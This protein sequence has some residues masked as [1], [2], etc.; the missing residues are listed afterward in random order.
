MA[1]VA[2]G[3]DLVDLARL[4]KVWSRHPRRFLERHFVPEEIAYCL[5]RADP[6]PSLGARFAAKEAF[7]KCWP[8]AL[9]WLEVW[10]EVE[11]R[12]PRLGFAPRLA[13]EMHRAQ[14]R[15]H[16]SLA[17]ERGYALA[18]VVLEALS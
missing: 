4:R 6:L 8:E 18:M 13:A 17:H 10:V 3:T 5:A 9:G 7:Q 14:L 15:A 1:V 2:V 11:G 12:R 16:L